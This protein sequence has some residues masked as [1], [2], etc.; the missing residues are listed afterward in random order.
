MGVVL[1][2]RTNTGLQLTE[3]GRLLLLWARRFLHDT[4]T[5]QSMV[6]YMKS[7]GVRELRITCS[8]TAEKYVLPQMAARFYHLYSGVKVRILSCTSD[9]HQEAYMQHSRLKEG[10]ITAELT[11]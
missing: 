7:D 10:F 6:A 4:N 8:T 5:M 11:S 2:P 1:F 3:T 9:V